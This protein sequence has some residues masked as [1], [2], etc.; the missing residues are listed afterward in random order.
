MSPQLQL[1]TAKLK[2]LQVSG[3]G[4]LKVADIPFDISLRKS[5]EMNT[6]GSYGKNWA[7]PPLVGEAEV[8]I[9]QAKQYQTAVV[10]QNIFP[11]EDSF[12]IE[13]M[14]AAKMK[15]ERTTL[16]FR[17]WANQNLRDFLLLGAGGCQICRECAAVLQKPCRHP[18]WKTASLEAYSVFVSALAERC[19]L[20]YINGAN[21]VT[22]FSVVLLR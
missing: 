21:T 14:N 2:E 22:Y 5:C 11:L 4:I 16:D 8:L 15:H 17:K 20:K 1:A 7:C 3:M 18:E 9:A 12:D 6:C 19:G 13:G 10:F